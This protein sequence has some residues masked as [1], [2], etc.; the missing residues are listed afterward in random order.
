MVR[1]QVLRVASG[2]RP[3]EICDLRCHVLHGCLMFFRSLV[4]PSAA[5]SVTHRRKGLIERTKH[6]KTSHE[7][8][9]DQY[10]HL[11]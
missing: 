9:A 2:N 11:Q 1:G 7:H 4:A 3:D 8:G 10:V 6:N 5:T